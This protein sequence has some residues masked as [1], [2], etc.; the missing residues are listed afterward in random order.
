MFFITGIVVT[1]FLAGILITKKGKTAADHIVVVWLVAIGLHLTAFY[2]FITGK[3]FS[4]PYLLGLELPLPLLHGPFLYVY[5]AAVTNQKI[6]GR[7]R[8]VH[9]APFLLSYIP[10]ISFMFSPDEH[11]I[12]VYQNNGIGYE[13]LM[14]F[15]V[16]IIIVSGIVYVAL[17][18]RL[19]KKHQQIVRNHFSYAEKINLAWLRYLIYGIG[20]IWITVIFGEDPLIY[21]TV[22]VF[23]ILLGYFGVKQVGI[24]TQRLPAQPS[25][26]NDEDSASQSGGPE[27]IAESSTN[28]A[29]DPKSSLNQERKKGKYLKSGLD[30]T[31][32]AN[33][34]A[35]LTRVINEQKLFTN[36]ELTL[37]ELALALNVHP[38][39]LSQVINTY[40]HKN[41]YDYINLKRVEEFNRIV[42]LP[43]NRKFTLLGLARDCGFNSKTSFNRNFKNATGFSP[44]EYLKNANILLEQ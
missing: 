24:F 37:A 10:F 39:N 36:P 20:V 2:L 17:S 6:I 32:A 42:S 3:N 38:N 19:L 40:E 13:T 7:F 43:E 35:A 25:A 41:F 12:F 16:L 4:Y 15:M 11:K 28:S 1:F 5:T 34:H 29:N 9:F 22:V 21:S 33:I 18:L 23:V 44:T 27:P 8:I 30:P 14:S 26:K 31:A